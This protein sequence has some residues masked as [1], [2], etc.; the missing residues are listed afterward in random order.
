MQDVDHSAGSDFGEGTV[1][2]LVLVWHHP[3]DK[4]PSA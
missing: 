2:E 3:R 4:P 1:L